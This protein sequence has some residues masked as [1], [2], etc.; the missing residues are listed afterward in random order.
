MGLH[1]TKRLLHNKVNPQQNEKA[2]YDMGENICK[3]Y[4]WQCDNIQNIQKTHWIQYKNFWLKMCR[5]E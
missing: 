3:S 2:T 4:I 5:S 1:Q